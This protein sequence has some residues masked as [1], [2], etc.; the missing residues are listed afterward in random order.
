MLIRR[1]IYFIIT[2]F[3][4][5]VFIPS[6]GL[7]WD[8]YKNTDPSKFYLL[9]DLKNQYITVFEKDA[10]GEYTKIVRRMLC[11]SGKS[12]LN[13][14]NTLDIG[15]PTPAGIW[16]IG[17]H[18][19]FG[20]F[21][22]YNEYARYWTHIVDDIFFHSVLF[23]RRD[24]DSLHGGSYGNLGSN[25]SHGCVRLYVEDAK[26]IY[27]YCPPGTTVKI[28]DAEPKQ[29]NIQKALKSSLSLKEYKI[30]Q[31]TIFDG[32]AMPNAHAWVVYK[33]AVIQTAVGEN[34]SARLKLKVDDEVEILIA[35]DPWMKVKYSNCEG[36]IKTAYITREKG[37]MQSKADA[38]IIKQTVWMYEKPNSRNI[39]DRIVKV[40]TD[41]SV[42]ILK[43]DNNGWTKIQ[44]LYETGYVKTKLLKKDWGVIRN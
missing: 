20:F 35:S 41:S 12:K 30:F 33:G 32:P 16:K 40:P 4:C 5:S 6:V 42:K 9:L 24:A 31:K 29:I 3:F 26:W 23:N 34:G 28:S 15:T 38:D 11:S 1:F 21:T 39:D 14:S 27:Y 36:Y 37:I 17:G 8:Q 43:A 10:N 18:E 25:V 44:Y 22:D 13:P 7:A 2:I 19:R